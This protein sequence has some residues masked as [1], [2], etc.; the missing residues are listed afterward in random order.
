MSKE[1]ESIDIKYMHE[2]RCWTIGIIIALIL[3]A[4]TVMHGC[5]QSETT[6]RAIHEADAEKF[7]QGYVQEMVPA[8]STPIWVKKDTKDT[9]VE[10]PLP[11]KP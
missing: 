11:A 6:T 10:A 9:K 2:T 5:Y 1:L 3:L 8:S 7:R 4:I